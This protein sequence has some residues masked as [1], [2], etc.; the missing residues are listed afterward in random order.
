MF[1]QY[2]IFLLRCGIRQ[3]FSTI[4]LPISLHKEGRVW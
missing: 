2:L 3:Q 1:V 4:L